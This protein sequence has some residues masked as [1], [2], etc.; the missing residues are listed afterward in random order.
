MRGRL[1][2]V[3]LFYTARESR[4]HEDTR[5]YL[6]GGSP[7]ISP[8]TATVAEEG[9]AEGEKEGTVEGGA[10]LVAAAQLRVETETKA[11]AS[12]V[13]GSGS[14]DNSDSDHPLALHLD[15]V[16]SDGDAGPMPPSYTTV[17]TVPFIFDVQ[18]PVVRGKLGLRLE[19]DSHHAGS[20]VV[21]RVPPTTAG[22]SE[23]M[24]R[25][26][27]EEGSFGDA[28]DDE[29]SNAPNPTTTTIL[30]DLNPI[31]LMGRMVQTLSGTEDKEPRRAK[32][33]RGKRGSAGGGRG[34]R[35][36]G[37]QHEVELLDRLVGVEGVSIDGRSFSDVCAAV[38][39]VVSCQQCVRLRFAS[40]SMSMR[41]W[42]CPRCTFDNRATPSETSR[43]V[44]GPPA[45]SCSMCLAVYERV[46]G[47][48]EGKG[49]AADE[50]ARG[51][52]EAEGGAGGGKSAEEKQEG[53]GKT[54]V[55][56]DTGGDRYV[57]VV[58]AAEA[59]VT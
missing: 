30:D 31:T 33:R 40:A 20:V 27:R 44:G 21:T 4:R 34:G 56:G 26:E 42:R 8:S 55:D 39:A 50:R 59:A 37:K 36:G 19:R 32:P 15:R 57:L 11:K 9:A 12:G 58:N 13:G 51:A 14:G 16:D 29:S 2:P 23:S 38:C 53:E 5:Q 3:T 41:L 49:V 6:D 18:L 10:L 48:E 7:A 46:V 43:E 45:L 28:E 47:G 54:G 24:I 52:A 25:G 22:A 1:Q 35:G 17:R